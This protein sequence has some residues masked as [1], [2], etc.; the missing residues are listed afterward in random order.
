MNKK[1]STPTE[2]LR[3]ISGE[4]TSKDPVVVFLYHL[5]RDHLPT[6]DVEKL[7]QDSQINGKECLFTNGY[8]A[9][10]A[11]NLAQRLHETAPQEHSLKRLG[12]YSRIKNNEV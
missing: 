7:V 2:A 12:E 10:Y 6:A 11:E 8:L 3:K 1:A 5:M 9:R 4:F